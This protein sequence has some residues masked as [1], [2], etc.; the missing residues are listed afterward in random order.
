MSQTDR[1]CSPDE[2]GHCITCADEALP[3]TV[4]R[5]DPELGLALVALAGAEVEIDISLVDDVIAGDVL[6]VHGGVAIAQGRRADER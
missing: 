1:I 3:A 4:L 5:V 2:R 6:L